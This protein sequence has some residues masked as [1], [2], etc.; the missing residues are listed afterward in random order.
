MPM[1]KSICNPGYTGDE[2]FLDL[3]ERGISIAPDLA[4]GQS[5]RPAF[6]AY[7]SLEAMRTAE[8]V[9]VILDS[10]ED[11]KVAGFAI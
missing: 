5:I 7:A 3:H 1:T 2:R 9:E 8:P 10:E 4:S 6:I 11:H